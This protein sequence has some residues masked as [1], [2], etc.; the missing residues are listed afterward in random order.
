M[1]VFPIV[2]THGSA[3]PDEENLYGIW[4]H[5]QKVGLSLVISEKKI[6]NER[7]TFWECALAFH[8]R[9]WSFDLMDRYIFLI[10]HTLQII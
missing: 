3:S 9:C 6:T 4:A 1:I 10:N 8:R 7:P 5:S 2:E